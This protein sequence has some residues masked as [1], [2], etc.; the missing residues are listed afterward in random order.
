MIDRIKQNLSDFFQQADLVLLSLCCVCTVFG[1]VMISSATRYMGTA[2]MYRFVL[3]QAVAMVLGILIYYLLSLVD[4]ELLV[5]KWKWIFFFNVGFICMLVPLGVSDNTGNRA[6]IRIPHIPVGIQPA[7]IVKITFI[8]LLAKQ[9]EWTWEQKHELKS[10]H[11]VFPPAFH[12]IFMMGLIYAISSDMGSA[13]VY[14]FIFICMALAAGMAWRWF[15]IGFGAAGVAML[16]L[17]KIG[18]IPSYMI[19]RFH[20]IADHSFQPQKAGWQQTRSLLALGS[21]RIFGQGLFHGTQTQSTSSASLP[22]RHTDFIFAAA[23]EELGF[24]GCV[25]I[26]AL[27]TAII[28]RCLYVAKCA[29]TPYSSYIC[30]GM[31]AMLIFQTVE[32]IGMC[33]FV[34]PVVGLTLPFFSYG[35]SSIV[36]LYAAMGIVSGI[37]LRAIPDR[38]PGKPIRNPLINGG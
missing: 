27:L 5:R 35:G 12:L 23:G 22:A 30:V 25:I 21:G 6:W 14:A 38:A 3:V 20:A 8:L 10:L 11:A 29:R 19:D 13:L 15:A 1:I 9:L 33:L 32:N 31:A 28:L 7:E 37:K 26:I 2:R 36:T 16:S 18:K 4:V 24:V 34:M 17:Y